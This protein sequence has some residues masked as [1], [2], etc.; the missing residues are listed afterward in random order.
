MSVLPE[1]R[2]IALAVPDDS[3][4]VVDAVE[5]D[6]ADQRLKQSADTL[7]SSSNSS[8]VISDGHVPS[9]PSPENVP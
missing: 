3:A 6:V 9:S 1:M 7:Q 8:T 4:D 5:S 2:A